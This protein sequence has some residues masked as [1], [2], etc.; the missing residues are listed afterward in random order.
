MQVSSFL[1]NVHLLTLIQEWL[2]DSIPMKLLEE[3]TIPELDLY[4]NDMLNSKSAWKK[5]KVMVL[6]D[7]RIGKTTLINA[8]KNSHLPKVFIVNVHS[9]VIPIFFFKMLRGNKND[10]ASTIGVDFVK[11]VFNNPEITASYHRFA[12]TFIAL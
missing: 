11:G 5:M 1:P 12:N 7:G 3:K 8:M 2:L 4:I 9:L 6:G 10:T